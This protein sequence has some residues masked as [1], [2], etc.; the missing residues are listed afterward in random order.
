MLLF[1][2][3]VKANSQRWYMYKIELCI[4][5]GFEFEFVNGGHILSPKDSNGSKSWNL[6]IQSSKGVTAYAWK[7]AIK[8][9]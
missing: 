3:I 5:I 9:V 7:Y 8:C 1:F 4:W 2:D 6:H